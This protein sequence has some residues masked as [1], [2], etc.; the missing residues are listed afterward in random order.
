MLSINRFRES[1]RRAPPTNPG[2]TISLSN[3]PQG[4][5]A[6]VRADLHLVIFMRLLAGLWVLQG[7]VQ[8]SAILLPAEPLFDKLPPLRSAAV[9]FFAIFDIVA[10]AGL[11]L[12]TPWGGVIWL[13]GALTQIAAAIGLPGFFSISWV[14]ANLALIAIYFVLTFEARHPGAVLGRLRQ[15]RGKP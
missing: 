10:A 5:K 1:F 13:L 7:L 8:W 4:A 2:A 12:A 3:H 14:A 9:I 6:S 11:W 15:R